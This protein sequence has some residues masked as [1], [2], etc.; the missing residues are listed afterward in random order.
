MFISFE[1][2][3]GSGKSTQA[4]LL[5]DRLREDNF[6]VVETR[7]PGGTPLGEAL[8]PLLLESPQIPIA[9]EAMALLLSAARAQHMRD[10]I[11]PALAAGVIVIADR[12]AD[13]TVAYQGFG[14][15]ANPVLVEKLQEFAAPVMPDITIYLD[16]PEAESVLRTAGRGGRNRL[17][18]ETLTFFQRVADGYRHLYQAEPDRWMVVD[19][20]GSIEQ[21]QARIWHPL[22]R[23][24][25]R[26]LAAS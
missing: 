15:G 10:V 11:Q 20:T 9:P 16:V 3:D 1:G 25:P 14:H 17:D 26:Q 18:G 6:Q 22:T 4:S 24:L 5:A 13:S 21:V 7:E 2:L 19:G 8:R 12:F 23:R